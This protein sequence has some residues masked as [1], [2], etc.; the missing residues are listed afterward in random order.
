MEVTH[1]VTSGSDEKIFKAISLGA[2]DGVNY[3]LN[4]WEKELRK[5]VNSFNVIVYSAAG[6]GSSNL[7]KL[8]LPE[9][10][11]VL[12]GRKVGNTEN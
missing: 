2:R 5:K 9:G 4:H 7:V 3:H 12:F 6:E 11:L 10:R 1:C 8:A